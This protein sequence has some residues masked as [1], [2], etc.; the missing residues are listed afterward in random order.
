MLACIFDTETTGILDFRAPLTADHQPDVV[1]LCAWLADKE[2]VYSKFNVFVHADTEIPDGAYQVHRIDRK[3]TEKVGVSRIRACQL[4]DS[5]ARK[6]DILVGHNVEFDI[7]IML[8][9]NYRENG[10]GQALKKASF[11]TMRAATPVCEIPNPNRPG[12]FKWPNLQEAYKKLVDPR[13]FE[14]A[15]DAEADVS[16][17]Y[18]LFRVLHK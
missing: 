18:E 12:Q 5:F 2:K 9:A 4:L 15:H 17:A 11:C 6:A 10:Q 3:M 1:Q 16:A 14:G 7:K 8:A 13:G